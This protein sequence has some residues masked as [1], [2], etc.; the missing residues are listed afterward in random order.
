[1][2]EGEWEWGREEV[3]SM[4]KEGCL[5]EGLLMIEVAAFVFVVRASVAA[6]F[7]SFSL[8]S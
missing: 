1:M 4:M 5:R 3:S 2:G 8:S 7:L 6:L